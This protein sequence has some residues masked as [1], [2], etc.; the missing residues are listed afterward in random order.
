M[1][2]FFWPLFSASLFRRRPGLVRL[3]CS[4]FDLSQKLHSQ[5]GT[6]GSTVALCTVA[7]KQQH[8]WFVFYQSEVTSTFDMRC[9]FLMRVALVSGPQ[10][11]R[12]FTSV[13]EPAETGVSLSAVARARTHRKKKK[14]GNSGAQSCHMC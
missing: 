9:I 6:C 14:G 5:V 11:T 12:L 2:L 3:C 10:L 7:V 1:F 4:V 13:F 8:K